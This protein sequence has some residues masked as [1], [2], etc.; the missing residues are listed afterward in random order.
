MTTTPLYSPEHFEPRKNRKQEIERILDSFDAATGRKPRSPAEPRESFYTEKH[1]SPAS[2]KLLNEIDP[3]HG[4]EK[5]ELTDKQRA[6]ER[7]QEQFD[8]LLKDNDGEGAGK[9]QTGP[10]SKRDRLLAWHKSLGSP[11]HVV[12]AEINALEQQEA[13]K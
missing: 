9:W 3:K 2:K 10:V 4:P 6:M 5:K 11:Q 1:I 8:L 7:K 12:D 13:K